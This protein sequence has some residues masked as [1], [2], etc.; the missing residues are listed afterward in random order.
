MNTYEREYFVSRLRSGIYRIT[1]NGLKIRVLT[2]T[3]EDEYEA[4][5]LFQ[6]AYDKALMESIFTEEE[7]WD[8]MKERDLWSDEKD[9]KIKG[10][11]KDIE[12]MKVGIFENRLNT[13]MV[14]QARRLLRGAE[15]VLAKLK[16]EKTELFSKTA[17]GLAFNE[18]CLF[19][20][21]KCC[22]V[23]NEPLDCTD[24]DSS[25]LFFDYNQ[26]LLKE[27]QL[28]ELARNDPWRLH[29]LMREH[30]PL[31]LNKDGRELS[32]DQKGILVWS[33]MYD[34][35]QESM[36]CPTEDVIND[37]DMLDGWFIIQRKKQESERAKTEM[38]KRTNEKIAN[39]DEILIMAS[40]SKEAETI[41]GMNSVHGDIVRKQRLATARAK[42]TATDLDFQDRRIDI[43]NQQHE[44]FKESQRRR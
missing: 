24:I 19:L 33:N 9:E 8:W 40:S 35:I 44:R 21:E 25:A 1:W 13:A 43:A 39:S 28:R 30:S 29:W 16:A 6:D 7:M 17:E 26:M 38:E 12:K 42:G 22:F 15:K 18:K 27:T 23:G 14:D 37:D 4:N 31:F 2:P 36:D 5:E 34:N 20:F 10:V 11:E 3:I 41:H 32:V